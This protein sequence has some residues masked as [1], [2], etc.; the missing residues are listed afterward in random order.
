MLLGSRAVPA[1]EAA[2][3]DLG[4]TPLNI[5][6]NVGSAGTYYLFSVADGENTVPEPDEL[7][8]TTTYIVVTMGPDLHV[9]ALS[10][11]ATAAAPPPAPARASPGGPRLEALHR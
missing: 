3:T 7:N 11:P 6:T 9:S 8:N 2:A 10:A 1:L 4:T 5:P